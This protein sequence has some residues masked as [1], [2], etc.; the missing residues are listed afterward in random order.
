MPE[1]VTCYTSDMAHWEIIERRTEWDVR[2]NG[3]LEHTADAV[4]AWR[5]VAENALD[6]DTVRVH[7]RNGRSGHTVPAR[8]LARL[9]IP[10]LNA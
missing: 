7:Y 1:Q 2:R 10:R 6:D 9:R 3:V 4:K 8:S 5:F